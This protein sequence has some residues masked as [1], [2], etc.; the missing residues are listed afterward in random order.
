MFNIYLAPPRALERQGVSAFM[1]V[2]MCIYGCRNVHL[3]V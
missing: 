3:W 1:G 2:E